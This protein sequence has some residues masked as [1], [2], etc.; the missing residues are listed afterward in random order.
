MS[1]HFF[2]WKL[3][4]VLI[5]FHIRRLLQATQPQWLSEPKIK[6]NGL[7]CLVKCPCSLKGMGKGNMHAMCQH[8]LKSGQPALGFSLSLS[9]SL[10]HTHTH[11]HTNLTPSSPAPPSLAPPSHTHSHC[12]SERYILYTT[13]S[14]YMHEPVYS[15]ICDCNVCLLAN[16]LKY[17][18]L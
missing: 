12:S 4:F 15:K 11:M 14:L 10:T 13:T 16:R 7:F 18:F 2:L 9:L 8:F 1:V 5:T 17:L 3:S 6:A